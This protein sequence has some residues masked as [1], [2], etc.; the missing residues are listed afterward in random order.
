[1]ING[2]PTA[3]SRGRDDL[4]AMGFIFSE[5]Y[6]NK[7]NQLCHMMTVTIN[8]IES[9][10]ASGIRCDYCNIADQPDTRCSQSDVATLLVIS[11]KDL[12]LLI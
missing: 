2:I 12:F 6:F 9:V 10:N 11:S 5:N 1:M 7:S 8:A 4:E 3:N